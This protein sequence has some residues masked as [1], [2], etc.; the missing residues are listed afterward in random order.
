MA[1]DSYCMDGSIPRGKLAE[2]LLE[3]KNYQKNMNY[4]LQ[5]VF[6]QVME[7]YIHLLCLMEMIKNNLEKLKSLVQKY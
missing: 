6:T 7:I 5:I 3:I 1:P 4:Q 2:A